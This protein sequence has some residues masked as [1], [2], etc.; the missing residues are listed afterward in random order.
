MESKSDRN[1]G[2]R[3]IVLARLVLVAFLIPLLKLS[4]IQSSAVTKSALISSWVFWGL[5][6]CRVVSK[7]PE[8][9][10]NS[11]CFAYCSAN[12]RLILE[13]GNPRAK[14]RLLPA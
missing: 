5:Y 9:I 2:V 13:S 7:L 4:P 12:L 1:R 10:S 6:F 8:R 11:I 3:V 14:A